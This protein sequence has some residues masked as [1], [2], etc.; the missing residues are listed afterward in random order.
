[1]GVSVN[2]ANMTFT[3]M[4]KLLDQLGSKARKLDDQLGDVN[5]LK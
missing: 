2:G 5:S 3:D 1:M 4:K